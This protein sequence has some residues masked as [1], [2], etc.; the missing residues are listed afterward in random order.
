MLDLIKRNSF[1]FD[2]C[3]NLAN[4]FFEKGQYN[5]ALKFIRQI[6]YFATFNQ[7]GYYA[8]WKLEQLLSKVSSKLNFNI[9]NKF[10]NFKLESN[11]GQFNV[12]HV[13]S[14]IYLT[15]GHTK[16]MKNWILNDKENSHSIVSTSMNYKSFKEVLI[17]YNLESNS[18][19]YLN[20][21]IVEKAVQLRSLSVNYDRIV[22][23]I[24]QYDIIPNLAFSNYKSKVIL[25][26]HADHTFW[27]GVSVANVIAQI[28][29]SNIELDAVRRG[30]DIKQFY[31]PIPISKLE[32]KNRQKKESV[33]K[34]LGLSDDSIILLTIA[35]A[36]KFKPNNHKNFFLDI[37]D[38]LNSDK[39]IIIFIIGVTEDDVFVIKH[40]QIIYLGVLTN[41]KE[42]E[43]IADI[44]LESYPLGSFTSTLEAMKKQT[45]VHLMYSPEDCI[46]FFSDSNDEFKYPK[47]FIEWKK[48][49]LTLIKNENK[50]REKI[51]FFQNKYLKNNNLIDAWNLK[52][53]NIY[54]TNYVNSKFKEDLSYKTKNEIFMMNYMHNKNIF[55]FKL[56]LKNTSFFNYFLFWN[57]ISH[58]FI[59]KVQTKMNKLKNSNM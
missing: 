21:N 58:I 36:Y 13:V 9:T 10:N 37:V 47:D 23:H 27:V 49:L 42:Y 18:N 44:Y 59:L 25:L 33:K 2:N 29:N 34:S 57:V 41:I 16:L 6:A 32:E 3:L 5:F 24:H 45:P 1:F 35:S 7:T 40:P 26:N 4:I 20:G 28:R 55:S 39:K 54:N 15:G 51:I 43:L 52:L 19:Y 14:E 53:Q 46:R 8:S 56:L 48:K 50:Y 17:H 30:I 31:L 11:E 12:L 38:I 22:L